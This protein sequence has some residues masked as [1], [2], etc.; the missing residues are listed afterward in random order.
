MNPLDEFVTTMGPNILRSLE[1]LNKRVA[2]LKT[3]LQ[4]PDAN[5][6]L[7][8]NTCRIRGSLVIGRATFYA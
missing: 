4:A 8:L 1:E 7:D 2:A 6:E 3:Q 5:T